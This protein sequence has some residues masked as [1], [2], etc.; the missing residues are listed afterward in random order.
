MKQ[1][2]YLLLLLAVML[3]GCNTKPENLGDI[4]SKY[5]NVNGIKST[6]GLLSLWVIALARP[7][8]VRF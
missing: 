1:K 6:Q 2:L 4:A 7:F 3:A 8:A 5:A